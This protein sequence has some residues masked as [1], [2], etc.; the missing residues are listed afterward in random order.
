MAWGRN[1]TAR[2]GFH[3]TFD[4][5]ARAVRCALD[6][7]DGVR[8]L[9][10]EIRAGVHTGE[11]EIVDGK[12][13]GIAVATGV[14][15]SA[16]AG[17]SQVLVCQTVRDLVTGSGLAFEDRGEHSLKGVPQRWHPFAASGEDRRWVSGGGDQPRRRRP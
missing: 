3:A 9:G 14:P 8:G 17:P 16:L 13:G 1:D 11:C 4:G 12:Y 5:P 6:V 7:A 10:V 15:I 2:D